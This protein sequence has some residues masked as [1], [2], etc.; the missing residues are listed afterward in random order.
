MPETI[1]AILTN[2]ALR[3]AGAIEKMLDLAIPCGARWL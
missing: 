1:F 2:E 3:G